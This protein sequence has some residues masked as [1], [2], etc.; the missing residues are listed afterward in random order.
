MTGPVF[1]RTW[2]YPGSEIDLIARNLVPAGYLSGLKAHLLLLGFTL[3]SSN[4]AGTVRARLAPS[5][6]RSEARVATPD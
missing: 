1:T 2:G 6:G 5:L 4:G 3:R